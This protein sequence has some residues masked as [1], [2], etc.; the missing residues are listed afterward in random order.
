MRGNYNH[1]GGARAGD[2]RKIRCAFLA[3]FLRTRTNLVTS[4]DLAAALVGAPGARGGIDCV[5]AG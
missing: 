4:V 2:G 1:G 5:S 3:E